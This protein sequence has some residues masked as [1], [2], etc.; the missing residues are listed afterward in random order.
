MNVIGLT[1]CR[2]S[3]LPFIGTFQVDI[4]FL[5]TFEGIALGEPHDKSRPHAS[6]GAPSVV[7]FNVKIVG[8]I[9]QTVQFKIKRITGF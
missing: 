5:A 7:G 2:V 6:A 1:T 8:F 4:E 3:G 9:K